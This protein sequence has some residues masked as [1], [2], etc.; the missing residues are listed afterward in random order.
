MIKLT[1]TAI[2]DVIAIEPQVFSD[3]RGSFMETWHAEK[4][5]REGLEVDFVQDNQSTSSRGTLR[6]LHYQL[7]QPQG[8]LVR[9]AFGEVFDV[10]VDLRRG[11]P[12][13]GEWVGTRL[14]GENRV[15]LWIPVG[16]AHGFYVTSELAVLV[17][18]CTDFY[19]SG[20]DRTI[21]W[22][23]PDLAVEWPLAAGEGPLLSERDARGVSFERAELFP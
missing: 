17:Y 20:D 10:A 22:D 16:F 11:S 9:V 3:R 15:S 19:R 18:K 1:P 8:K 23:D 21:R 5:A 7:E 6:G 12:T 13:F 2:P 14:S 4:F